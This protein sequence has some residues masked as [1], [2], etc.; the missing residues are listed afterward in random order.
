MPNI[1]LSFQMLVS[2]RN[3][4]PYAVIPIGHS[5][6]HHAVAMDMAFDLKRE[7]LYVLTGDMVSLYR[8][9]LYTNDKTLWWQD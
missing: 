7:H 2:G 8:P 9:I 1:F 6:P 5:L 4:P 3:Q